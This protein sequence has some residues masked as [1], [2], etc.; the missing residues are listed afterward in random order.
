MSQF[1]RIFLTK[2]KQSLL[3]LN[4]P[5]AFSSGGFLTRWRKTAA[6]YRRP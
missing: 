2:F 4:V 6:Q 1:L 5:F 3:D